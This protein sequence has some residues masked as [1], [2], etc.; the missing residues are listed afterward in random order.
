MGE[1]TFSNKVS[2]FLTLDVVKLAIL[3]SYRPV[4]R[5]FQKESAV[6]RYIVLKAKLNRGDQDTY[7][8]I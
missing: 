1:Q 7:V 5:V 4:Y 3:S 2:R 8:R 6:L